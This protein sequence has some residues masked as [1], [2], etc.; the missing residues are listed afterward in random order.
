MRWLLKS[1]VVVSVFTCALRH[2]TKKDAEK[3][4][5]AGKEGGGAG[6]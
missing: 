5:R 6:V 1:A 4:R 3:N 2:I